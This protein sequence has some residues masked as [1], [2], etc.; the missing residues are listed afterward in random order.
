MRKNKTT[1][2]VSH[3]VSTLRHCDRIVVMDEGRIVELG[4]HEELLR[5]DGLYAA[6]ERIQTQGGDPRKAL[7]DL[8]F[9]PA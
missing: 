5:K 9:S 8:E 2:L 3:R 6:L 7:E 4:T 1:I